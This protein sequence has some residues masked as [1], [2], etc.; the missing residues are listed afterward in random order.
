MSDIE[1]ALT[2]IGEIATRELV[3]KHKPT[4]LKE[5]KH[6]AMLGGHAAKMAK[7]DLEKNLGESVVT[8]NNNLNYQYKNDNIKL[9]N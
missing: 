1:V 4:N 7:E 2:D 6:L 3:R 9:T 8:T 5:N